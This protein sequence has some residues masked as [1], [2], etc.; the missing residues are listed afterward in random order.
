[1]AEVG[2]RGR[3]RGLWLVGESEGGPE[4]LVGEY[5]ATLG[6]RS[7]ST[8]EVYGRVLR[9]LAGWVAQWPGGSLLCSPP[10]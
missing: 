8:V 10:E 2:A 4:N 6:G 9:S 3:V 5:L 7:D 1:M